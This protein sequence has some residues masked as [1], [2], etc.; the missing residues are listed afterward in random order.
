MDIPHISPAGIAL[1]V[2][3]IPVFMQGDKELAVIA[4]FDLF[5]KRG[6]GSI[7]QPGDLTCACQR[8]W[9]GQFSNIYLP[10]WFYRPI[11]FACHGKVSAMGVDFKGFESGPAHIHFIGYLLGQGA[12]NKNMKAGSTD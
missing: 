1:V 2:T 10:D 8:L 7:G 11:R 9:N 6:Q 4:C 12:F 5:Y 3:Q